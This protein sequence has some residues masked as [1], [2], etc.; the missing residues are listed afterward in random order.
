MR[1]LGSDTSIL[2]A[3]SA[4]R[5]LTAVVVSVAA[6]TVALGSTAPTAS[7]VFAKAFVKPDPA[8]LDT[9]P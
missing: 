4:L 8:T 9:L 1:S 6:L 3:S 5:L 7:L 2:L